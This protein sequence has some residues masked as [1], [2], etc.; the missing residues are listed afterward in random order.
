MSMTPACTNAVDKTPALGE[1]AARTL[2]RLCPG[3]GRTRGGEVRVCGCRCHSR[4]RGR[5]EAPRET[6]FEG[7]A[8]PIIEDS[9]APPAPVVPIKSA[10][11]AERGRC[12]H[13]G[14]PCRGRFLP[15]HDAKLKGE[16]V[17]RGRRNDPYALAELHLRGWRRLHESPGNTAIERHALELAEQE[18]WDLVYGA[19]ACRHVNGV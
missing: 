12:E 17:R 9:T 11:A 3:A 13:C 19:I 5:F 15:G 7:V 18:G 4:H 6:D 1:L 14:A 2:H 8:L 10:K 16:L